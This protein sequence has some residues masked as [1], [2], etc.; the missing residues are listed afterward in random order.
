MDNRTLGDIAAE[1]EGLESVITLVGMLV[2]PAEMPINGSI[3]TQETITNAF[4]SITETL[5]NIREEVNEWEGRYIALK[6][7][8]GDTHESI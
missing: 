3:P 1:L 8:G 2:A 7:Q 4:Y 6:K 5:R